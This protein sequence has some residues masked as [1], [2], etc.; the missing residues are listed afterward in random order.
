MEE[1]NPIAPRRIRTD[2]GRDQTARPRTDQNLKRFFLRTFG[3]ILFDNLDLIVP[4]MQSA[5]CVTVSQVNC[6]F[7]KVW[8]QVKGCFHAQRIKYILFAVYDQSVKIGIMNLKYI[9]TRIAP[10]FALIPFPQG[11]R[12]H[13]HSSRK[14]LQRWLNCEMSLKLDESDLQSVPGSNCNGK[15]GSFPWQNG[16]T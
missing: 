6:L 8:R 5:I 7:F 10:R 1:Y 13:Q 16:L 12:Q 14:W 2:Q 11:I 4:G 9:T 3:R 15:A